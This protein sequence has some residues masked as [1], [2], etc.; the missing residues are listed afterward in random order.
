MTH[1]HLILPPDRYRLH[2]YGVSIYSMDRDIEIQAGQKELEV[3]FD[4]PADKLATLRSEPAPKF[5]KIKGWLNSEAI[6]LADSRGK[7]VLLGFWGYWCRS[8]L[9]EIPKLVE[10]HGKFSREGLVII[11]IHDDSLSSTKE[12][13]E[14]LK[15]I[16]GE[17]W[18]GRG[19]PSPIALD[20]GGLT[21]IEGTDKSSRGATGVAYGIYGWPTCVLIDRSGN[22]V[23]EFHPSDPE[24][25]NRLKE[26]L[27]VKGKRD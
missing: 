8:C 19:V 7:V 15:E 1:I 6:N 2:V 22:V 21:K 13:S 20:G 12:L 17:H 14:K 26:M 24:G 5:R 3:N 11:G 10:L 16:S 25:M 18:G 4:L 27:G 23:K 9:D